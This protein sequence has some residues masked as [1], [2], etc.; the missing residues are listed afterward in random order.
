MRTND[1]LL[2]LGG[3]YAGALAAARLARRGRP[4]TLIDSAPG[5]TE[6]IRLHQVAAG[7]DLAPIPYAR[8]FRSLPVEVIRAR[9]TAIDRAAKEVLTTNG[10]VAYDRLVYALGSES[11]APD[12][13]VSVGDPLAIRA[14]LHEAEGVTVVGGGLTGIEL[15][16]EIAE[17]HPRVRVS[18]VDSGTIGDDLSAK[19][20]RHLREWF[21]EHGVNVVDNHRV[22]TPELLASDLVIW[23]GGFRLSPIAREAG[24]QVNA[25]GQIVVD[26]HLRSSD[27]SIWAIGDAANVRERRMSC[28]LALP[29]GAYVADL[30]SGATRDPF[31]F[32]FAIRC[33]SIGRSD[34]IVQF[35]SPDDSP[36]ESAVVGRPAAW[37]KE[38]ICRYAVTSIRL[39][40][41]GLHYSW[42][43][44]EAA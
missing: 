1:T 43:K 26:E 20:A 6:R 42:P 33:I 41:R 35:V 22:T 44:A 24:L 38:L 5:F 23:C 9:V 16:S 11:D 17:R 31:R 15:A 25:R 27:P 36:R 12:G 18:L 8:L 10:R 30:L 21:A 29:M 7:D 14:R 32:A 4:V 37:I 19:A 28:A 34:G 3:G 39:E 13:A 40:S 2:I